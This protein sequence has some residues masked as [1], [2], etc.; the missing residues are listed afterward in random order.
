MA[1]KKRITDAGHPRN[2]TLAARAKRH[3]AR[4]PFTHI[5][6]ARREGLPIAAA[7]VLSEKESGFSNVFGHDPVA[8]IRGGKVTKKRYLW[9]K[10]RRKQGLG[11]QGVGYTQ[12]T[13]Y[14]FQDRADRMG[15]CWKPRNQVKVGVSILAGYY[16]EERRRG[17]GVHASLQS[18][19]ARYN[20]TGPAAAA[21]GRDFIDR[22]QRWHRWLFPNKH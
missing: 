20:G 19:A 13:W 6:A 7:F 16:K 12:L 14:E 3:G 17:R 10:A 9:Y 2:V 15:G 11:M 4:Y 21:Y 18:A 5:L 8:S 22:Y 1:K